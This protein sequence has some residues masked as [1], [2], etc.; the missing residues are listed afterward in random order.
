MGTIQIKVVG[1]YL[2]EIA[3][4]I[5]SYI[6]INIFVNSDVQS[7]IITGNLRILIT[8]TGVLLTASASLLWA[9]FQKSDTEFYKWLEWKNALNKYLFAIEYSIGVYL[10]LFFGLLIFPSL[11]SQVFTMIIYVLL[12]LGILNF[13]TQMLNVISLIKL[14]VKFNQEFD[15]HS[16]N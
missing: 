9:I 11:K 1:A 8:L 6:F 2:V 12:I 4:A 3:V 10:I 15:K 16:K 5:F 13:M 7:S 14:N